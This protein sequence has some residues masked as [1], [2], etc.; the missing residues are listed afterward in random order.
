M[1]KKTRYYPNKPMQAQF[2]EMRNQ[3]NNQSSQLALLTTEIAKRSKDP[4]ELSFMG[5][6]QNSDPLV[7]ERGESAYELY[8]DLMRD[9]KVYAAYQKRVHTIISKPWQVSPVKDTPQGT[10]HASIITEILKRCK[11]DQVC[12]DL[13]DALIMGMSV[14]EIVWT[15]RD[16]YIVPERIVKRAQRRFLFKELDNG[17]PELR[18]IT[19]ENPTEGV[20]LPDRK[21]IVHRYGSVDD[22][23]YGQGI[24][25]QLFWLVYFK[26]ANMVSWNKLN[27]RYGTPIPWGKYAPNATKE[28]RNTLWD[29][30][31]AFSNDGIIMTPDTASLQLLEASLGGNITSHQT[32]ANALD[33]SIGAVITGEN[34]PENSGGAVAAASVERRDILLDLGQADS[35]L[36]CDTFNET[37]M[38]WLCELNGFEMCQVYRPI[39]E[40]EDL[41][42]TA[43]TY[44]AL[45]NI[46]FKPSLDMVRNQ[47]GEGWEERTDTA[48]TGQSGFTGYQGFGAGMMPNFAE[49]KETKTAQQSE[50]KTIDNAVA[51]I[52]PDQFEQII[53]GILQPFLD[54]VDNSADYEQ[55]L[56]ALQ[57]ALP[58]VKPEQL[59]NVLAQYL[60]G[61][62]VLGRGISEQQGEGNDK[63]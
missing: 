25:L 28:A 3:V 29:A 4:Q 31:M 43:E 38:K 14:S 16:G 13:L 41:K 12:K 44:G 24:G 62:G 50:Q 20:S 8:S 63:L 49:I 48:P 17:A 60:F 53:T 32:L 34:G 6:V 33:N 2:A 54:A 9:A 19:K 30:L 39:Q 15:V 40:E 26:R 18:L 59:E 11:F 52:A 23:P 46:G 36:Q 5:L 55:A 27:D 47:F 10:E 45:Y 35:D 58:N 21:F 1:A 51:N 56:T 37:F 22:N 61:S 7:R 42:A 57:S